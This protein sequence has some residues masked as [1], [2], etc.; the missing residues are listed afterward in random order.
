V[1]IT[2]W[3]E[4]GVGAVLEQVTKDC[5]AELTPEGFPM[6]KPILFSSKANSLIQSH[7]PYI[8]G[9]VLQFIGLSTSLG[10]ICMVIPSKSGQTLEV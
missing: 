9:S 6:I 3:C 10:I 4:Q 7:Y 5:E 2:D 1:L 8:A